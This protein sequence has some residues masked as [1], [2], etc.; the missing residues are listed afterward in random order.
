[1]KNHGHTYKFCL[2]NYF[3]GRA[4]W[5][6]RWW[7]FQTTEVAAALEP[8][9]MGPWNDVCWQFFWRWTILMRPLQRETKNT[10][11]AG[12]WKLKRT[13]C[14]TE[15]TREPLNLDKRN[16][17][18]WKTVDMRTSFIWIIIDCRPFAY[19]DS[20]IFKLLTWMQNLHQ[21]TWDH[22]ILYA[23]ISSKDKQLSVTSLLPKTKYMNM[24]VGSKFK[25]FILWR[26]LVN[27]FT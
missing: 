12:R 19:G 27:R 17:V 4:F 3:R 9:N 10:N 23:D 6:W 16:L 11:L 14:L 18:Q 2:N 20:G 13:Y 25:Y 1:M 22:E 8:V 7:Y 15:K 21:S 5:I 24:A 26:E